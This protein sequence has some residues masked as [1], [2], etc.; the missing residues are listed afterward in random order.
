MSERAAIVT[1]LREALEKLGCVVY[2]MNSGSPK[3]RMSGHKK[4]TPDLLVI[5]PP[6]GCFRVGFGPNQGPYWTAAV[7]AKG[8]HKDN[9][10]CDSCAAQRVERTRLEQRGVLYVFARSVDSALHALG[11]APPL[12]SNPRENQEVG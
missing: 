1:P 5:A 4:G 9:C 7:E 11:L 12:P 2:R 10:K 3:R 8:S 6:G